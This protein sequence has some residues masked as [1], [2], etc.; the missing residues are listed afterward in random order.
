MKLPLNPQ[1]DEPPF[2]EATIPGTFTLSQPTETDRLGGFS[3][4]FGFPPSQGLC[5]LLS[6]SPTPDTGLHCSQLIILFFHGPGTSD[7]VKLSRQLEPPHPDFP[8]LPHGFWRV[9]ALVAVVCTAGPG[10]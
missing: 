10:A 5:G 9:S 8:V 1:K 7:V 6:V 4:D 3:P 2:H